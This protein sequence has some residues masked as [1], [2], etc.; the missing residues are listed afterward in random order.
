V[1]LDYVMPISFGALCAT[2][3]VHALLIWREARNARNHR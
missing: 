3:I 1:A 2:I